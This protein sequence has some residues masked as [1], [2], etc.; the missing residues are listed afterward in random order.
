[1]QPLIVAEETRRGI[2]D[3]LTTTFP[4]TTPGFELLMARFVAEPGT[5]AKGPYVTLGLPFRKAPESTVPFE[6]I[7]GF[8][9]HAHQAR[10]F[11]RLSGATARSTLVA[12]GT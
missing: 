8:R 7:S 5:L 4:A 6:W 3:F 2:A 9:P 11:Q 10:A 1:M 12:T